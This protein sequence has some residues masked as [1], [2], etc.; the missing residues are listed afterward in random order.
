MKSFLIAFLCILL[1]SP[2]ALSANA[3]QEEIGIIK[4]VR[5]EAYMIVEG[6]TRVA[7]TNMKVPGGA[8]LTT[9]NSCDLGVI[10]QDDTLLSLGPNSDIAIDEVLFE[11]AENRLSFIARMFKGT[12]AFVSGQIAKLAPEKVRLT[13]PEATLGVRGTTFVVAIN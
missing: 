9:G 6:T 2:F 4:S 10:F 7:T 1:I 11:P 13:T 12:F 5:G 3:G 8:R